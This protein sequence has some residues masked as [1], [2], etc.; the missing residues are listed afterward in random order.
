MAG[1]TEEK[2]LPPSQRK[3]R[4]AREKGQVASST[5]FVNALALAAGVI[6]LVTSWPQYVEIFTGSLRL[7]IDS[8]VRRNQ[9]DG[10]RAMTGIIVLIAQTIAPL[11]VIVAAA[12]F[13]GHVIHKKG[14]IFSIDPIKPDFNR[15]SIGAGLGRIFSA[16]NGAE[17]VIALLRCI[18]WFTTAGLI[19]WYAMPQIVMSLSCELPC[20]T[21]TGVDLIRRL[22][23]VAVLM[24]IVLGLLDLPFQTLMFLREQKM[25]RTEF[26]RELKETEGSPEF[27]GYRREQ[28]RQM[29]SA[30]GLR[31]ASLVIMSSGEAVAI[32]YDAVEQ[33]IPIV[34]AKGRG[35]HADPILKAAKS[36]G[37][38]VEVDP[39]LATELIRVGIGNIVPEREFNAVAMALVRHGKAG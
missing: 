1:E 35:I 9:G 22:L 16:K 27:A 19:V 15:I 28:Y 2:N 21:T 30:G 31:Q 10:L 11:L 18:F 38:P 17:F 37:T 25:S 5:D 33:P 7:G 39:R 26:K 24:I 4:K 3:L 8:A 14:L 32:Q 29:A 23:I 36:M 34:V 20:V 12:A 6:V 13:A